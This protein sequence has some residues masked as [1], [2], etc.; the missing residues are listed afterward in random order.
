MKAL[1]FDP[2]HKMSEQEKNDALAIPQ[3]YRSF[4]ACCLLHDGDNSQS[5]GY[6]FFVSFESRFSDRGRFCP[7][8]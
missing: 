2:Q 1:G 8:S 7:Y 6:R 3:R 4:F 5:E